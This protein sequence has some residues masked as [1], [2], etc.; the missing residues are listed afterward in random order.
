MLIF[1]CNTFYLDS[2]FYIAIASA[3]IGLAALIVSIGVAAKESRNHFESTVETCLMPISVFIQD[4][5]V[6]L[7]NKRYRTANNV[8][9]GERKLI[10]GMHTMFVFASTN[11]YDNL[12]E[13]STI[14]FAED[15]RNIKSFAYCLF[16]LEDKYIKFRRNR[17]SGN[18]KGDNE[19]VFLQK[20]NL[21]FRD[22]L[23]LLSKYMF[24]L[25]GKHK[26]CRMNNYYKDL[27]TIYK[28]VQELCQ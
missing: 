20:V 6:T 27:A 9:E 8:E 22:Y 4:S 16:E 21:L 17:V 26:G 3:I 24:A 2:S 13:A 25:K 15:E 28:E 11:H 1:E 19:I 10:E 18:L 23:D 5:Y 12:I 7:S 14:R